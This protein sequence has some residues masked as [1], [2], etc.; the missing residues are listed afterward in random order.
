MRITVITLPTDA[1]GNV[2]DAW[3]SGLLSKD[4]LKSVSRHENGVDTGDSS[5]LLFLDILSL[6][7]I[8][9]AFGHPFS[10]SNYSSWRQLATAHSSLFFL[11]SQL[12]SSLFFL[13]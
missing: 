4:G 5:L 8:I 9:Q 2:C 7:A 1:A 12:T 13:I 11:I 10:F 3:S 6:L